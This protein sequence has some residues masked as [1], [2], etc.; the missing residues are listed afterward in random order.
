MT[1]NSSGEPDRAGRSP[2][3]AQAISTNVTFC[4]AD[5]PVVAPEDLDEL[6]S[7]LSERRS[8][9]RVDRSRA[10]HALA[11][12]DPSAGTANVLA[13]IAASDDEPTGVRINAA[14][15]LGTL[16][17]DTAEGHLVDLLGVSEPRV[18]MQVVK[19][20]GWV[21]TQR[22]LEAL[23][24]LQIEDKRSER[25]LL[26]ARLAIA[27]RVNASGDE[28]DRIRGQLG[29]RWETVAGTALSSA[30][31]GPL[32][33][34]LGTSRDLPL[35]GDASFEFVCGKERNIVF[36]SA[37]LAGTDLVEALLAK[38]MQAGVVAVDEYDNGQLGVRFRLLTSS[39]DDALE[40][41]AVTSSGEPAFVG[42]GE[43][44]EAG[45]RFWLRDLNAPVP[46]EIIGTIAAAS[47]Q[48]ELRVRDGVAPRAGRP[49][50]PVTG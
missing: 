32:A 42:T 24:R 3:L 41:M 21:G 28:I 20:L 36:L 40:I 4:P 5:R 11:Q 9:P 15:A 47:I 44:S 50:M 10:V 22:S 30:E 43:R 39:R 31:A 46:V 17:S 2:G 29:A 34:S 8:D 45:L 1:D 26:T 18:R 37:E 23:G 49:G 19:A 14:A 33:G 16:P 13:R 12:S 38:N 48:L 27:H 35:A 7:I 6:R 25:R